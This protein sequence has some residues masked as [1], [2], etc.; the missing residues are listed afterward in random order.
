[1]LFYWPN[2]LYPTIVFYSFPFF[3]FLS[4]DWYCGAGV[5]GLIR[6]ISLALNL[7]LPTF[8]NNNNIIKANHCHKFT[9]L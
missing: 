8:L 6:C 4:I 5:L 2:L 9:K 3:F 7:A 1:M